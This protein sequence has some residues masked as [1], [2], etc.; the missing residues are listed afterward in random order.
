MQGAIL[1]TASRS[2]ISRL[3]SLG[4]RLEDADAGFI[5]S[6]VAIVES[7]QKGYG[8]IWEAT[9]GGVQRNP[10]RN[11]VS[12]RHTTYLARLKSMD[13]KQA[14]RV[15]DWAIMFAGAPYG[16]C[17]LAVHLADLLGSKAGLKRG[18]LTGRLNTKRFLVCSEFVGYVYGRAL[19]YR[20]RDEKGRWIRPSELT[21]LD[22]WE[23]IKRHPD[24]W[25]V[26]QISPKNPLRRCADAVV[27]ERFAGSLELS[28]GL[29][30]VC[31]EAP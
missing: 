8:Y 15:V 21:P 3:I 17:D 13:E 7:Y 5:P 18:W 25:E 10:L 4:Q 6:H 2:I 22:I 29:C 19:H 14:E 11:Y 31:G 20:F 27:Q 24:E 30:G 1:L 26:V 23:H 28:Q 12:R 9:I 16:Y